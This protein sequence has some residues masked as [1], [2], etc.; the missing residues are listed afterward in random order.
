R[1]YCL[2]TQPATGETYPKSD[3]FNKANYSFNTN[4]NF[5]QFNYL[6]LTISVSGLAGNRSFSYTSLTDKKQVMRDI[7]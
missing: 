2:K 1:A 5:N 4:V 6:F 3:L 7:L